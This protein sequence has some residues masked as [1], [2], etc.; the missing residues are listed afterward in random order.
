MSAVV[1]SLSKSPSRI[2]LLL[3]KAFLDKLAHLENAVLTISDALGEC[4][5]GAESSDGL[6][7]RIEVL[8]L[9]L[10]H[11]SEPTRPY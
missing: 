2:D 3:R 10:I 5:L 7:A 4:K 6:S 9:S 8:D 11:I 1:A